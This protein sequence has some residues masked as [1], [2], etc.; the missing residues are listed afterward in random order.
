MKASPLQLGLALLFLLHNTCARTDAGADAGAVACFDGSYRVRLPPFNSCAGFRFCEP[1]HYCSSGVRTQCPAGRYGSSSALNSS[2][3]SGPCEPGHYCPPASLTGTALPCGGAGSYCPEGSSEPTAVSVGYYTL[4][5]QGSEAPTASRSQQTQCPRGY[6]CVGGMRQVCPAGTYGATAGLSSPACSGICPAG[7]YCPTASA[8]PYMYTCLA[9]VDS[10]NTDVGEEVASALSASTATLVC[11]AGS[12][13]PTPV[14]EG[15]YAVLSETDPAVAEA[16]QTAQEGSQVSQGGGFASQRVCPRGHFCLGGLRFPCAAGTY[17]ASTRQTNSSCTP[18][19]AGFYCPPASTTAYQVRCPSAASYCPLGSPLPTA[20]SVGHYSTYNNNYTI[21]LASG[22]NAF[23]ETSRTSQALCEIG[24]YCLADGIKRPCPLGRYGST[25]GLYSPDCTSYCPEGYFC[26]EGTSLAPPTPAYA[27]GSVDLFCPPGSP[28]PQSVGEGYYTVDRDTQW[29]YLPPYTDTRH[30]RTAERRCEAGSYCQGGLKIVCGAGS[31]GGE[32][33][34]SA[35][36]C[37]GAC[38]EGHYCPLGS[39][40]PT[41]VKCGSP[42]RYCKV[43]SFKPLQVAEGYYSSGGDMATRSAQIISPPGHFA[44]AGLLYVCPAGSYG[45]TSGLSSA[46]CSGPCDVRGFYCPTGSVSPV[47]RYCGGDDRFCPAL[48]FAPILV[49]SGFYSA[50]YLYESCPPGQWR[51]LTLLQASAAPHSYTPIVTEQG[52]QPCQLCPNGTY[53]AVPGDHKSLCLACDEAQMQS[54]PGRLQCACLT[55]L[56]GGFLSWFNI[57]SSLCQSK[58]LSQVPLID[59]SAWI[60]NTSNHP[61][62][63]GASNT[64]G[65]GSDSYSLTRYAQAPCEAGHYC[66]Q[67]LRYKCPQGRFGALSQE[68]RA[69]CEG[70]CSAGYFC[71]AASTSPMSYPCGGANFI[72]P[73]ESFEPLLVPA[74]YYSNEDTPPLLRHSMSLCPMGYHCPGDGLR[75]ACGQGTFTDK[76]GT[77]NAHC[78][79][80]CDRGHYCLPASTDRR[81]HQ[82]GNST[83]YCPRGSSAPTIVL[84]GFYGAFTG[85]DAGEQFLWE[86]GADADGTVGNATFSVELPCEAG[87]YCTGGIKYP[88]APG[89]YGWRVGMTNRLCGGLCAAGYYCP[90]YMDPLPGAPAYTVWPG[91]PH[92]TATDLECGDVEQYCPRGS[93]YPSTVGGGNYSTGGSEKARSSAASLSSS[94][95]LTSPSG[96]GTGGNL[97]SAA[98]VNRTRTAQRQ[99]EPGTYCEAGIPILCPPGTFGSSYGL[100]DAACTGLCPA[101]FYCPGGAANPLPCPGTEY[102]TGRVDRCSECP[103]GRTTPLLCQTEKGCCFRG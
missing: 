75:Y 102:S 54:T 87:Y 62:S 93:H 100:S 72:C 44:L 18:C 59:S 39:I 43:G 71:L 35:A 79:G 45:A 78:M 7:W 19:A 64:P 90:S 46:S 17:G 67:G 26:P 88:C 103:G 38:Q 3:C 14:S 42:D 27:C 58:V 28:A 92:L 2:A 82:C 31:W 98:Q 30:I 60:F 96:A 84:P 36:N 68:T 50:D 65:T 16:G 77:V 25:P 48:T 8:A 80:S 97:L 61:F 66:L 12:A 101:G 41:E 53:K 83:V 13:R 33:G 55:V 81:Q 9:T 57:T 73:E 70:V 37:S 4:D 76:L 22:D 40:S 15:Y 86:S 85:P 49:H 69:L 32:F 99:C 24:F 10:R 94:G 91:A 95:G 63:S 51:N 74:G 89:T 11:P 52:T 6:Y 20:V 47:M 5:A 21:A 23:A 34:Q 56:G 1:G 29:L